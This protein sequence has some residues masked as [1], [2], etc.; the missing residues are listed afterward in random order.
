MALARVIPVL[1]LVA[2]SGTAHAG[3][4]YFVSAAT[5]G[6]VYRVEDLN[7]DGDALDAGEVTAW[8]N[9]LD[10]PTGLVTDGA[11][12]LVAETNTGRI[13]RLQDLNGDGDALDVGETMLWSQGFVSPLNL[14]RE[15]DGVVFVTDDV[16]GLVWRLAD[17]NGDGDALDT[18]ESTLFAADI[19]GAAGLVIAE[20][21]LFVA[22]ADNG[23]THRVMD[24]DGDGDALDTGENL[25]H[26]VDVGFP[27]DLLMDGAG[28]Y[29]VS[30]T[31]SSINRVCDLNGDGDGQDVGEVLPYAGGVFAALDGPA[32]MARSCPGGLLVAEQNDNQVTRIHDVNGDGDAFDIG[33]VLPYAAGISGAFDIVGADRDGDLVIDCQDNCPDNFNP[34]QQD[35]NGN[36][37]GD[38]CDTCPWDCGD[39]DGEVGIVDF[40]ALLAQ[41]GMVGTSCDFDGGGAGIVDFLKLLAQWGPCP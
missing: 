24:G 13:H 31:S 30:V 41:W 10:L 20:G 4:A 5:E 8:A 6:R 37:Q 38:V 2:S 28:C 14:A 32:G 18:G 9:G 36:G 3:Q 7:G 21:G 19:T 40:L 17:L 34:D 26:A 22:S 1:V 29:F 12:L 35:A 39:F 23:R 27:V 16:E 11:A 25:V 33:D 15:L